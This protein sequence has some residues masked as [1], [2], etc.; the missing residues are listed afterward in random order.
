M[1]KIVRVRRCGEC[2]KTFVDP[3][4]FRRHKIRGMGCRSEESL[5]AVGFVELDKGWKAP[6]TEEAW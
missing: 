3:E 4:S 6:R 5:K 2:K 1:A